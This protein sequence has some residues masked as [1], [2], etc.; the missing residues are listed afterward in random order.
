MSIE[1]TNPQRYLRN[2]RLS[3]IRS[4][5]AE[6]NSPGVRISDVVNKNGLWHMGKFAKD[7]FQFF[8]ELPSNTRNMGAIIKESV[9]EV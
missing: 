9:K 3:K 5:L 1:D 7:Y 2:Y 8:G 6:L 4:E